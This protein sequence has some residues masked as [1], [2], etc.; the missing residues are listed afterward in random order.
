MQQGLKSVSSEHL[1][2]GAVQTALVTIIEDPSAIIISNPGT[3]LLPAPILSSLEDDSAAYRTASLRELEEMCQSPKIGIKGFGENNSRCVDTLEQK[4][5][6]DWDEGLL[7]CVCPRCVLPRHACHC[8][9]FDP[10]QQQ[11]QQHLP[12]SATSQSTKSP[13]E[14]VED[15]R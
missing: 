15:T 11:S 13:H 12:I 8:S 6:T 7:V 2:Q 4:D 9:Y 10:F 3:S 14:D 1:P 5:F